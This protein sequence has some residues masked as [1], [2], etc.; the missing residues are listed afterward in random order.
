MKTRLAIGLFISCFTLNVTLAD[1]AVA[2]PAP[3]AVNASELRMPAD[4][5]RLPLVL[6][7]EIKDLAFNCG[8]TS[9]TNITAKILNKNNT[10][11]TYTPVFEGKSCKDC[12]TSKT[13]GAAVTIPAKGETTIKIDITNKLYPFAK[14]SIGSISANFPNGVDACIF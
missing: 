6:A 11:Q 8:S 12:A 4:S 14:V 7:P 1:N 9:M 3:N 5:I 10:A 13:N 2:K